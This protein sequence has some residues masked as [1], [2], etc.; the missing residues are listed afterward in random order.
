MHARH[1]CYTALAKGV[2]LEYCSTTMGHEKANIRRI[3][4]NVDMERLKRRDRL[5]MYFS[6]SGI[7]LMVLS[8]IVAG[9][10]DVNKANEVVVE[11]TRSGFWLGLG[12][13]AAS[14]A[15]AAITERQ[16]KRA[17]GTHRLIHDR[18]VEIESNFRLEAESDLATHHLVSLEGDFTELA[19]WSLLPED[20]E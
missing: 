7:A 5:A 10:E 11:T 3:S 2:R 19:Q 13:L 9:V 18:L 15:V 4:R 14:L 16:S 8:P 20:L 1:A 6:R 12:T 17:E